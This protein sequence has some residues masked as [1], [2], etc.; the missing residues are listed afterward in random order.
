M[1]LQNVSSEDSL[2]ACRAC[3][4]TDCKL[5][6]IHDY[7]LGG[8]FARIS[9]VPVHKDGLPQHLCVFCSA[10]VARFEA[11]REKVLRA[12]FCMRA[13]LCERELDTNTI[14]SIDRSHFKL[15]NNLFITA[16]QN[17]DINS[18][19]TEQIKNEPIA[20]DT[21]DKYNIPEDVDKTDLKEENDDTGIDDEL[22]N[23][24]IV[25]DYKNTKKKRR[26]KK[27]MKVEFDD[28]DDVKLVNFAKKTPKKRE[29]NVKKREVKRK[30]ESVIAKVKKERKPKVESKRKFRNPENGYM[31]VFD[32]ASF[33]NA[34]EVRV[35]TLSKEDQLEEIATRKESANYLESPFQCH[36]CGKGFLAE[37]PYNNH[38]LRHHPSAGPYACEICKVRFNM[39]CRRQ[40][41]QDMHRLKFFCKNCSFVSRNRHQARRHYDM[42]AGKTFECKH[43]G[44]LFNKSSTYLSHVRLAH[45]DMHVSCDLCG[46][47]FVGQAG[48]KQHKAKMHTMAEIIKPQR[49]ECGVCSASFVSAEALSRHAAAGDHGARACEQC[50][51][52]CASETQLQEHV[53]KAHP[54]ETYRCEECN[55]TFKRL[56]ALELH[57]RRKHLGQRFS[58]A[59]RHAPRRTPGHYVCEQCG[60]VL[61][62]RQGLRYHL[63][64][65]KG[66]NLKL[67]TC[68]ECNKTFAAKHMRDWHMRSHTGEKPY[69]CPECPLAFSLK[70]NLNRHHRTAHLGMRQ[71]V[72]C[73]ICGRIF[74]TNSCVRVHIRS[75]HHGQPGPKR[76]RRKRSK[77]KEDNK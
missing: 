7:H 16:L 36:D 20:D 45:P 48:L 59:G 13:K 50:G 2:R 53:E 62:S 47:A 31:P 30:E 10:Q 66:L 33:E 9:G 34:F 54:K 69:Q 64:D 17:V 58:A 42:H 37:E 75:V 11:F 6:S 57:H 12:H 67:F 3:L 25:T 24:F 28:D 8:A 44:K 27:K 18:E 63:R 14:R 26:S 76:D 70:G 74:T 5:F 65:H 56:S 43:C 40:E 51:E 19:T 29:K 55:M 41:H 21:D 77:G 52:N 1:E 39:Q 49:F 15:Y 71:S 35:V 61:T 22:D 60:R 38:Q 46:E 4:V 72:P 23:L 68:P 73:P 32:F